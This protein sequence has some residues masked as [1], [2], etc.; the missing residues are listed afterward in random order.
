VAIV[1]GKRRSYAETVQGRR[2]NVRRLGLLLIVFIAYEMI[3]GLFVSA[4]AVKSR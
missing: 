3:A 2:K 4:Y 1:L